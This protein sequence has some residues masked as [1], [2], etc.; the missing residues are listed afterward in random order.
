MA[1]RAYGNASFLERFLMLLVAVAAAL[2][3]TGCRERLYVQECV[4]S[5]LNEKLELLAEVDHQQPD[6]ATVRELMEFCYKA[7]ATKPCIADASGRILPTKL[8]DGGPR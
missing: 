4:D 6:A 2:W 1:D 3:F 8:S 5:C 7:N